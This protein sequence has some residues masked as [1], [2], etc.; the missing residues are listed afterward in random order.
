M[1]KIFATVASFFIAVN[2]NAMA[3]PNWI[4]IT[5]DSAGS[6]YIDVNNIDIDTLGDQHV[7]VWTRSYFRTTQHFDITTQKSYLY[8]LSQSLL[9]YNCHNRLVTVTEMMLYDKNKVVYDIGSGQTTYYSE[10]N[11]VVPGTVGSDIYNRV[12]PDDTKSY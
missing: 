1:N 5:S 11:V 7:Q 4:I 6:V 3:N 12:C 2:I 10:W 9:V 8:D